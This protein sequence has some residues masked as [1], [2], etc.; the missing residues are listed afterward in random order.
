M[1]TKTP[2]PPDIP[3]ELYPMLIVVVAACVGGT[4][5]LARQ[6]TYHHLHPHASKTHQHTP[7]L[8][9]SLQGLLRRKP[10]LPHP[11]RSNAD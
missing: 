4:F 1:G 10:L 3:V 9:P 5:A 2:L 8:V 6:C 11:Q 7:T